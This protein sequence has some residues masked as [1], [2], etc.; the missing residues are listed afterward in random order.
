MRGIFLTI[1]IGCLLLVPT[2]V[3]ADHAKGDPWKTLNDLSF[4]ALQL[5]KEERYAEAKDIL[6]FMEEEF[7][8]LPDEHKQLSIH[9]LRIFTTRYEESLKALA[10]TA[11]SHEERVNSLVG[12]HLLIDAVYSTHQPLWKATESEIMKT[13]DKMK[14]AA[15][16]QELQHF[17]IYFNQFLSKYDRIHPAMSI[18][19]PPDLINRIDSYITYLD[20]NRSIIVTTDHQIQQIQFIE[21]AMKDAFD[22]RAQDSAD[23]SILWL[24]FTV[25]GGIISTLFYVGWRKYS[26]EKKGLETFT[27][28]KEYKRFR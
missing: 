10:N 8:Q 22:E 25:G 11:I 27:K 21:A 17:Y 12:L 15:T 3:F 20:E 14:E 6:V 23:P 18:D 19:I 2:T 7:Q 4:K 13:I 1:M 28:Q 5:T 24:I 26:G 16:N 9:N